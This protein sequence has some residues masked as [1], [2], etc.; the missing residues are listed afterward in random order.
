MDAL[1]G[2][3]GLAVL[4]LV[5]VAVSRHRRGI[6]WRTVG[7]A[8]ALQVAFAALVLRWGPGERGLRWVSDRV[9]TLI[10]YADQG[11]V[12]VFGPLTEVGEEGGTIFALSVLPVIIFLGALVG[13][14]FYLRVIQWATYVVGGAL[15][16]LLGVSKVE[17]LYAGTVIFLGQS[18]APL[19]IGPYLRSLRRSQL[20]TVMAAGFAAAAG[21]TLVGYSLL[22]AP[23]DYLLA[24][25][26]MNAPASL[27]M[28]KIMWPDS[29]PE[30]PGDGP[31]DEPE[32]GAPE[33]DVRNV[34]DHESRNVIDAIGRG[35]IAGGRIAVTVGA[36]LIAFIALIAL[37]NGIL[38]AVG[39]WFG[40]DGLTFEKILGWAL[41]P[42]AWLLGV[43]WSEAVDAGS[44]IGQKTVLN[45][46]V[47]YAD[48]GPQVDSL[49]PVTV[50]VVTFA[51]AGFANFSSIAIQIGTLGSL[52]PERRAVVAELGLRA[53]LAGSLANLANAAIAGLVIGIGT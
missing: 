45:E 10:G 9:A 28:A 42:L 39:G 46:F 30:G 31:L 2:L 52:V 17:S 13:L 6:S 29:T 43:P 12:F 26:V 32:D 48:F 51:L 18:E 23:L 22:G 25:T 38:G 14:L 35:A 44:W 16:R 33:L 24:A 15:A 37:A 21:S 4:L 20:F 11:T 40:A 36:L 34:R 47:A 7:V 3:V 1:R 50:A 5:A 41:A 27:L 53:L 49:T 19:M 8:L